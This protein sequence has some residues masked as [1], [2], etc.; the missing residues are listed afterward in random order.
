MSEIIPEWLCGQSV[1]LPRGNRNKIKRIITFG[2]SLS[3]TGFMWN[4]SLGIIPSD[5][6]YW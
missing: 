5:A 6:V 2:D 1:D 4:K 3:D